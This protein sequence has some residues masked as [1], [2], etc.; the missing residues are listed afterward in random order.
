MGRTYYDYE[1][2]RIYEV[3]FPVG[4]DAAFFCFIDD[5]RHY[6][7]TLTRAKLYLD[8]HRSQPEACRA[9]VTNIPH[10][11]CSFIPFHSFH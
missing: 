6:F 5:N 1:G 9:I 7:R 11:D 8:R 4:S 2:L 3:G 10:K